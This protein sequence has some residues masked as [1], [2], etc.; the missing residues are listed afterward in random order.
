MVSMPRKPLPLWPSSSRLHPEIARIKPGRQ[1]AANP[2]HQRRRVRKPKVTRPHRQRT[3]T[4]ITPGNPVPGGIHGGSARRADRVTIVAVQPE[5][6]GSGGAATAQIDRP[7]HMT[8]SRRTVRKQCKLLD[9]PIHS[10]SALDVAPID[11]APTYFSREE[12]DL[13]FSWWAS[14]AGS[15]RVLDADLSA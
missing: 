12:L 11:T 1:E 14:L 8:C 15:A 13:A 3:S 10:E 7:D 4:V 5:V 9:R 6:A 2:T